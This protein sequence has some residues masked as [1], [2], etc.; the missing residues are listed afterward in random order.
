MTSEVRSLPSWQES[1]KLAIRDSQQLLSELE[2]S[3]LPVADRASAAF[4]VF[5]PREFLS[6]MR[7][8]D[9]TDPLLRQVLPFPSED[10]T[11]SGFSNDPVA[12][13]GVEVLP[14][15]LHKYHGRVLLVT[16][17]AC[18]IHCRYCF[19]R[20]FPYQTSPK[21]LKEWESSLEY[22]KQDPTITEVILSGGDPLTV[23]DSLLEELIR[24]IEDIPQVKR[25][26]IHTRMPVVIPQRVTEAFCRL[27]SQSRLSTWIVLHINHANEIDAH[28]EW[29]VET[30]RS[31]GCT[32]LNQSVLLKGVN[33]N[34][35]ALIALFERLVDCQIVPYYLNQLDRV[36]G[37]AHYEV[38][39]A[40]GQR[41]MQAVRARLP[42]YA[43][44][45]YVQDQAGIDQESPPRSKTPL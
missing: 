34:E 16:S 33:D 44:P 28:V 26:R 6:R 29:A 25:L 14:G 45:L 27:L 30:L 18:G 3:P 24:R 39:L 5:V 38:L 15:V 10:L 40:T 20:H 37:A 32:I 17:G 36:A 23:V 19:R 41:L 22:I 21:S 2:L 35:D 12:D 4:P 42:G 7:R 1:M 8:G 9:P 31:A 13:L 43:V 11:V